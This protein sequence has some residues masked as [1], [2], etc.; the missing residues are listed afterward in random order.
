MPKLVHEFDYYA[1][2]IF[3]D[4]GTGPM[5]YNRLVWIVTGGEF[6]GDRLKGTLPAGGGDWMT[7]GADGYGRLDVNAT[8]QTHDGANIYV[9]YRGLVKAT[10]A[11]LI[12][13][14]GGNAPNEW[15]DGYFYTNPRMET[16]DERYAWVNTTFWVSQGRL[17]GG[18]RVEYQVY[19]VENG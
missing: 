6:S 16:S 3:N 2:L 4:F 14:G 19:R 15:N 7:V 11:T 18:P 1:D 12:N 8:L 13:A 10:E 17:V 5:G 9:E